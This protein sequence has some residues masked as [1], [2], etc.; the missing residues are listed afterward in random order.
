MRVIDNFK[1]SG[2]NATC[3]MME[4]PKLF[5]LDF[6]ATTIVRLL[7]TVGPDAGAEL[8]GK[9]FDLSSAYKQYPLHSFDRSFIRI[10]VPKPGEDSCAIYGLNALPFGASGSVSGFLRVST[11]VFHILTF[12]DDFPIISRADIASQS[13]QHVAMLLD[14]LGLRFSREGKKWKP[15]NQHMEVLGV[16]IDFSRFGDGVV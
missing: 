14:L 9:T 15:F 1:T 10:A 11:A 4:K 8:M 16:V 6:L 2:V 5:G 3:G 12:F 13:E 7:S